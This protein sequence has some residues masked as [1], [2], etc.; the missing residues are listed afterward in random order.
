MGEYPAKAVRSSFTLGVSVTISASFRLQAG[1]GCS[2][3]R[4]ADLQPTTTLRQNESKSFLQGQCTG[5][6]GVLTINF[7]TFSFIYSF[8]FP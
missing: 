8:I 7:S 4:G 6:L 3:E 5:F 2:Q 1:M